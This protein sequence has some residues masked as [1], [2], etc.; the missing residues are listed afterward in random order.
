MSES[1]EDTLSIPW[2]TPFGLVLSLNHSNHVLS[3]SAVFF[4]NRVAII[5]TWERIRWAFTESHRKLLETSYSDLIIR[6]HVV[7]G[8][9]PLHLITILWRSPY[10]LRHR[11]VA[12]PC[13]PKVLVG[14]YLP[15]GLINGGTTT[16]LMNESSHPPPPHWHWCIKMTDC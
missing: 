14:Y 10:H 11:R 2:R 7:L 5:K 6:H 3:L 12:F 13:H 4:I 8:Y 9:F 16:G 1:W 15:R